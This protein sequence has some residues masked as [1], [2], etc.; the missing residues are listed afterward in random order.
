[1]KDNTSAIRS[2]I[3]ERFRQDAKWGEQNHEAVLW[4][5]ILGEE[6][7]E[8]CQAVNETVFNNG[9]EARAKGGYANMRAEA[10]Q[11]AAVAVA[12]IESLDKK[13]GGGSNYES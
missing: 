2:V 7:G 9:P 11:V 3:E 6:F 1:M 8:L 10:V 4:I 13:F 12:F 5:G